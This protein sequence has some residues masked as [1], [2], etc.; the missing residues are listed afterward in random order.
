MSKEEDKKTR[1]NW[2][3][4]FIISVLG[5]AIGVGLSFGIS[6]WIESNK[7]EQAQRITAM[8]VIH[9]IDETIDKLKQM[10]TEMEE[11][12]NVTICVFGQLDKLDSIS[13]DTLTMVLGFIVGDDQ[14][15]RFDMSKEQIFNSSPDTWQNLGSM[16]FID[17]VQS[18]YFERQSF[19]DML[20][21]SVIWK[22]PVPASELE[23]IHFTDETLNLD[24]Y[25]ER[26]YE[27]IREFLK[28]KL[29]DSHV[30][31][32]LT[33]AAYRIDKI[34]ELIEDWTDLN[35]ENKFLMS[36]TDEEL[37][38]YVN[39]INNTG[40][41]VTEKNLVGTWVSSSID[42]NTSEW[43]FRKDHTYTMVTNNTSAANL[44]FAKGKI[45]LTIIL[46]GPW[47]IEGDSLII[48]LD[49]NSIETDL[50]ERDLIAMPGGKEMMDNWI[51]ETRNT[52][53]DS[54]RNYL[55]NNWTKAYRARLDESKNKME[56]KGMSKNSKGED[57]SQDLYLKRKK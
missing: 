26:Y 49:L 15:F 19:Q 44:P 18:F 38:D 47:D 27:L 51:Q 50:D 36:I 9:D 55:S 16:K 1:R 25:M 52:M 39:S 21:K 28:A 56:L 5:T 30:Q 40:I 42:E 17:N 7:K 24:Q 43:E 23:M 45:K 48:D 32:Y 22:Q 57:E 35:N 34:V 13:P 6:H 29:T 4:Q 10:K 46:S 54:Y 3:M 53:T 11:Q 12:Y 31:Y 41:A 14:D 8:M 20:N 37:A 33:Y 2:W